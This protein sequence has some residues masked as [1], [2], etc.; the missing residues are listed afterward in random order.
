LSEGWSE[1]SK[2]AN[3][4]EPDAPAAPPVAISLRS[5]TTR[6]DGCCSYDFFAKD[7]HRL[8][9]ARCP[10]YVPTQSTRCRLLEVME[11]GDPKR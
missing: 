2:R 1:V 9:C 7:P 6:R 11:G 4:S 5:A 10:F 8:A 3:A